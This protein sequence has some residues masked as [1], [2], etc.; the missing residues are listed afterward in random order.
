[1]GNDQAVIKRPQTCVTITQSN[2]LI[3]KGNQTLV[4]SSFSTF[5]VAKKGSAF[6]H[7]FLSCLFTHFIKGPKFP[8]LMAIC[9]FLKSILPHLTNISSNAFQNYSSYNVALR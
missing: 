7:L 9:H 2:N 8:G 4:C 3:V 5:L 1:M 6:D